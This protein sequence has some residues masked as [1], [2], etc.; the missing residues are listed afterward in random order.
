MARYMSIS[1]RCQKLSL[2]SAEE[3]TEQAEYP[4]MYANM[5]LRSHHEEEADN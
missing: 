1:I 2:G 3:E 4:I 5:S